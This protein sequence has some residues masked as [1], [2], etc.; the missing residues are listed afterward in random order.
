MRSR[1][2]F[3]QQQQQQQY[4][5]PSLYQPFEQQPPSSEPQ[6]QGSAAISQ[7]TGT[8]NSFTNST[9]TSNPVADNDE[10]ISNNSVGNIS[11]DSN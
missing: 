7:N 9:S 5:N 1:H 3:L 6:V 4:F 10:K 11:S 2:A 8:S